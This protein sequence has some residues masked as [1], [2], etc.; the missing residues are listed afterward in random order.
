MKSSTMSSGWWPSASAP[1][2]CSLSSSLAPIDASL[3]PA[4]VEHGKQLYFR[5]CSPCHGP[6]AVGGGFLPDLRTSQPPVYEELPA[7][8]LEGGRLDRGM[9]EFG[10]FLRALDVADLREYLLDRRAALVT[11]QGLR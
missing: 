4:R 8:V 11:E 7:I 1:R 2:T 5:H 9:P 6:S 3:E 10:S